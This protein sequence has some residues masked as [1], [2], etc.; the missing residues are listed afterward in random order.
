MVAEMLEEVTISKEEY[1]RLK[2]DSEFLAAL[3]AAGVNNWDGY[4]VAQEM[5]GD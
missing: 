2:G 1:D 3:E 4:E 5:V